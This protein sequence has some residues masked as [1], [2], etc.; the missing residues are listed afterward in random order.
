MPQHL[1][2]APIFTELDGGALEVA[3]ILF[4]FA[5]ETRQERKSVGG[6]S[7]ESGEYTVVVKTTDLFRAG[8]HDGFAEG[9][10]AIARQCNMI[11]FTDKQHGGAANVGSF[12]LHFR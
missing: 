2:S 3:V 12:I 4:Q 1:V 8:F 10:L 11:V 9:H 7:S 6:G 5:F